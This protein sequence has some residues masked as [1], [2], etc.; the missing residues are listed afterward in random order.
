M[1]IRVGGIIFKSL[2]RNAPLLA[3][4]ADK[5]MNFGMVEQFFGAANE[6]QVKPIDVAV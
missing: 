4:F 5:L 6:K 1:L 2:L 3:T